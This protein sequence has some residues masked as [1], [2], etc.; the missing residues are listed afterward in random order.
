MIARQDHFL[1][2]AVLKQVLPRMRIVGGKEL[3]AR[4]LAR[5]GPVNT[6]DDEVIGYLSRSSTSMATCRCTTAPIRQFVGLK[7][8]P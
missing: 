2:L 4:D 5:R 1:N 8:S 6:V 3:E 7:T